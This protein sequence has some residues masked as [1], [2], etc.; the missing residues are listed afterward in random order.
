MTHLHDEHETP[1]FGL[2]HDD[3]MTL[4][5]KIALGSLFILVVAAIVAVI[6]FGPYPQ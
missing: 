6:L 1:P 3:P 2:E 4:R 5:Q